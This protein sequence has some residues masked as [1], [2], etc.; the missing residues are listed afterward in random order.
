[1]A[2]LLLPISVLAM[3][4]AGGGAPPAPPVAPPVAGRYAGR[5]AQGLPVTVRVRRGARAASWRLSYRATCSDGGEIR[6][7]YRSGDGTPRLELSR[8]GSFRAAGDEPAPFRDG[9]SG[10]A[11]YELSGRLGPEG[12]SGTWRIEVVP[13]SGGVPV[14]CSSGPVRWGLAR[15]AR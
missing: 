11:R 5:T 12:G 1:M 6:G 3:G 9:G 13:P 8:S 15:T 10:R 14:T 4:S 7:T 2:P